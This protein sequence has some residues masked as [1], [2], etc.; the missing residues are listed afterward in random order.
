MLFFLT[1]CEQ[2]KLH[3]QCARH[4][5]YIRLHKK[6]VLRMALLGAALGLFVS[7]TI[8]PVYVGRV[9]FTTIPFE[10]Q[11]GSFCF[12]GREAPPPLLLSI[13]RKLD[14]AV[15]TI[16]ATNLNFERAATNVLAR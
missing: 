7:W 15:A 10:H 4:W 2:R 9:T 6:L 11:C 3:W 13:A 5:S 16:G 12:D 1:Y 14:W 8:P